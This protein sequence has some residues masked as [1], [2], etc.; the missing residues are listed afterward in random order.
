MRGEGQIPQPYFTLKE[1]RVI[2]L[3]RGNNIQG[4]IRATL[5]SIEVEVMLNG[6][7]FQLRAV[8][9]RNSLHRC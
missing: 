3:H 7:R 4:D 2:F 6:V 5:K 1:E 8:G 9:L